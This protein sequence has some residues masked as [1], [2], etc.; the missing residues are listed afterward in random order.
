MEQLM[1][2]VLAIDPLKK[3]EEQTDCTVCKDQEIDPWLWVVFSS[4]VLKKVK[5]K[6]IT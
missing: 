4:D 5:G 2:A 1:W 3:D 6:L